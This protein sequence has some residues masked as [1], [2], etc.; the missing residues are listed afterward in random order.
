MITAWLRATASLL[1]WTFLVLVSFVPGAFAQEGEVDDSRAFILGIGLVLGLLGLGLVWS[2]LRHRRFATAA[3]NW[4]KTESTVITSDI[5]VETDRDSRGNPTT[6]HVPRIH[7][8]YNVN[9]RIYEG[10]RVRFGDVRFTREQGAREILQ[11]YASGSTVDVR[12][13][14]ARPEEATIETGKPGRAKMILG[15][16]SI[17]AALL[18]LLAAAAIAG[19]A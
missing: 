7:Y 16:V 6:Y 19:G 4:P 18:I 10:S 14:P 17:A 13:D 15:T 3:A 12:Y 9:G 8:A 2:A 1:P 11:R 5:A